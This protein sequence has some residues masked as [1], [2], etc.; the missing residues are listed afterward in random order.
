MNTK[1]KGHGFDASPEAVTLSKSAWKTS[2]R[3]PTA[4]QLLWPPGWNTAI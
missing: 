3:S 4:R 1:R 2:L